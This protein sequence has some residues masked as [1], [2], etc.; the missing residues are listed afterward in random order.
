MR[1]VPCFGEDGTPCSGWVDA[2]CAVTAVRLARRR[3]AAWCYMRVSPAAAESRLA[4]MAMNITRHRGISRA[5]RKPVLP[6]V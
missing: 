4:E 3:E 2:A 1:D 6:A 5:A